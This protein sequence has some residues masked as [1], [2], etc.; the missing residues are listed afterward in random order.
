MIQRWQTLYIILG[1]IFNFF[2][3]SEITIGANGEI[4]FWR[5]IQLLSL[6]LSL[7]TI[8]S[9]KYRKHQ[10]NLL[11][12]L[13]LI[14]LILPVWCFIAFGFK[15]LLSTWNY[16][17]TLYIVGIA[18]SIMFY[19]LAIKSIKQDETLIKSIDRIR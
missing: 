10:I 12:L 11:Y 2:L 15:V 1:S 3:F 6:V 5:Y 9:Y 17:Y 18:L 4:T 13:V 19:M 8:F 16:S 14:V 7:L